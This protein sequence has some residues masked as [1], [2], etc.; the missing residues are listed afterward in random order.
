MVHRLAVEQQLE[1]EEEV[2]SI[3]EKAIPSLARRRKRPR[4]RFA[5]HSLGYY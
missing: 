1:E 3:A 4:R 5:G 2:T